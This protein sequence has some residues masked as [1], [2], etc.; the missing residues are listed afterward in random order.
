[1]SWTFLKFCK[2][3]YHSFLLCFPCHRFFPKHAYDDLPFFFSLCLSLSLSL[4]SVCFLFLFNYFHLFII[5][6]TYFICVVVVVVVFFLSYYFLNRF[7]VLIEWYSS[8]KA[9]LNIFII[10]KLNV[11]RSTV[12]SSKRNVYSFI[13][14]W[15]WF[16]I[17]KSTEKSP[18]HTKNKK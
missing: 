9:I 6:S 3:F 12:S 14:T 7:Q 1:M 13:Y 11:G 17:D 2:F 4:S 16:I 15:I 5:L 8:I 18:W 10:L